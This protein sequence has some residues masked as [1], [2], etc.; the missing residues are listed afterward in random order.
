MREKIL[1]VKTFGSFSMMYDGKSLFGRKVGE[2]QFASMMQMLIHERK[3]GVSRDRLEQE[4]FGEREVENVHHALQSVIYNAK[5][6]LEKAGLPDVNYIE[7]RNG[8]VYWNDEIKV[9]EDATEFDQIYNRIKHE[10]NPDK[11]IKDLEKIFEIYTG[12]FLV[13][14]QSVI[15]VAIE[16]RRYEDMFRECVE[17]AAGLYREK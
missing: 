17:E 13:K 3:K 10:K 5:K 9:Q 11:K 4:L 12:E 16:A 2:T 7:I 15:W 1:Q 14:R 8:V 6:R